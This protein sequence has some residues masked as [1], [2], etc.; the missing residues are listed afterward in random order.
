ME[1]GR[2][3]PPVEAGIGGGRKRRA[4]SVVAGKLETSGVDFSAAYTLPDTG[5]GDFRFGLDATY[6]D[7]YDS[8]V[9]G[10]T[11]VVEVAGTYD[12]Q[13]GNIADWRATGNVGWAYSDFT[14]LVSVRWIDSLKLT[15]PDGQ[16][17]IQPD[18]NIASQIYWDMTLGYTLPSTGTKFQLGVNNL[19]DNQ[20]PILYQNNV[21]NANTDVETYDTIGRYFFGSITQKF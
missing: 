17:G 21:I 7:K 3:A 5:I 19:N 4:I 12:R 8:T 2:P 10:G 20:P 11:P 15:D 1:P 13:Y 14:A 16:P 18:L 9:I 6:T